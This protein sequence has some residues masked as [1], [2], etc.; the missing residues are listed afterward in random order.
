MIEQDLLSKNETQ[1]H[2]VLWKSEQPTDKL[3]FLV[4]SYGDCS[5]RYDWIA[6]KFNQAGWDVA[7]F[8]LFAH[9]RSG[10]LRGRWKDINQLLDELDVVVSNF[11]ATS[12]HKTW[13][14]LGMGF[15]ANLLSKFEHACDD[16][17]FDGYLFWAPLIRLSTR[18]PKVLIDSIRYV[19]SFTSHL[20]VLTIQPNVFTNQVDELYG[21]IPDWDDDYGRISAQTAGI[22][23]DSAKY[24]MK[25]WDGLQKPIWVGWGEDDQFVDASWFKKRE[26]ESEESCKVYSQYN[27][28]THYLEP[29][30]IGHF[31]VSAMLN[32]VK[33]FES[34]T[35]KKQ[36]EYPIVELINSSLSE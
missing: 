23:I 14:G 2:T 5:Y 27:G 33:K 10:G 29:I 26:E 19:N 21:L 8:D 36:S 34:K 17:V 22:L 30:G 18:I 25:N 15:G 9:G 16:K 12:H 28:A 4:H 13:V 31:I 3:L 20:S 35:E 7:S 32:W 11:K 24:L 6:R 1:I